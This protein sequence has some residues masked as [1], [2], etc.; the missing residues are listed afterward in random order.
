MENQERKESDINAQTSTQNQKSPIQWRMVFKSVGQ[1]FYAGWL[2]NYIVTIVFV[3]CAPAI[4]LLMNTP[5]SIIIGV[6]SGITIAVWATAFIMI[7]H[8]PSNSQTNAQSEN[9]AINEQN[10]QM[11][12]RESNQL[13]SPAVPQQP[14]PEGL[15]KGPQQTNKAI[16]TKEDRAHLTTPNIENKADTTPTAIRFGDFRVVRTTSKF[17]EVEFS[18]FYDGSFGKEGCDIQITPIKANGEPLYTGGEGDTM[19]AA[20]GVKER[21]RFK[22]YIPPE[23]K[24]QTTTKVLLKVECPQKH[25]FG[26]QEIPYI[27]HW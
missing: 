13:E 7:H 15:A 16:P 27:I 20:I 24:G 17:I 2:P 3:L 5:K 14:R 21:M 22:L 23:E 12:E 18:Y 8:I 25:P 4:G 11:A 6:A 10:A 19:L 1:D 26:Y 9:Q